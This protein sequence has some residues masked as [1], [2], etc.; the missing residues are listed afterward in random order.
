MLVFY[1]KVFMNSHRYGCN[2]DLGKVLPYFVA[3]NTISIN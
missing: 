3:K 2:E 1:L